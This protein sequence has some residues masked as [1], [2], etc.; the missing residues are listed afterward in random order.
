MVTAVGPRERDWVGAEEGRRAIHFSLYTLLFLLSF[1]LLVFKK[2][3]YIQ[4]KK[5]KAY[6]IPHSEKRALRH[7][8]ESWLGLESQIRL[9]LSPS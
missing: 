4:R 5:C 2:V 8:R 1:V 6:V 7:R 9:A 3:N